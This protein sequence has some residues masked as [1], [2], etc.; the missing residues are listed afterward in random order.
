MCRHPSIG[1]ACAH[2]G[3][4]RGLAGAHIFCTRNKQL[5]QCSRPARLYHLHYSRSLVCSST[6]DRMHTAGCVRAWMKRSTHQ[7]YLAC[8]TQKLLRGQSVVGLCKNPATTSLCKA[9]S[10]GLVTSR[11]ALKDDAGGVLV[12]KWKL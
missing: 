1:W 3:A 10:P 4:Q 2:K 8:C 5:C 9:R 11:V 6:C 7:P 12:I